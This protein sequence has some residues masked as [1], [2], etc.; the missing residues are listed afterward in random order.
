MVHFVYVGYTGGEGLKIPDYWYFSNLIT[1]IM[2]FWIEFSLFLS[3]S[4]CFQ[5]YSFWDFQ[6]SQHEKIDFLQG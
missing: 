6:N 3:F 1:D 4:G 5:E 2:L